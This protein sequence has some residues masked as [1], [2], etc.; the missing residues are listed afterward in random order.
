MS[1]S[2]IAILDKTSH[3][4]WLKSQ[5]ANNPT[6][7]SIA[8]HGIYAGI[9]YTGDDSVKWGDEYHLETRDIIDSLKDLH[10]V[11]ILI[12][13]SDYKS[14]KGKSQCIHCE[15]QYVK[16]LLRLVNHA[17]FFNKYQWK[18]TTGLH[19]NAYMFEYDDR[20]TG[21]YSGR[22]LSDPYL[23]RIDCSIELSA[24]NCSVVIDY[25]NDIW[26]KSLD[27]NESTISDLMA[28][29]DISEEGFKAAYL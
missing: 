18:M 17:E 2:Q 16:S 23:D 1:N 15:R 25:F 7:V 27:I 13:N 21:L 14:C 5:V 11:R 22:N 19:L 29:Q 10:N 9:T 3:F 6:K 24:T 12:G 28:G 20:S 4:D 26:S 8:S